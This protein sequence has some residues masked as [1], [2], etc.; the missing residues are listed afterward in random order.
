[1]SYNSMGV[2]HS[3][4]DTSV[5]SAQAISGHAADVRSAVIETLKLM[6]EPLTTPEITDLLGY[7]ECTVQPRVS[8]LK[9]DGLVVDSGVRRVGRFGRP[10]I[11]WSLA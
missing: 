2:G 10:V 8:E 5:L 1:M 3:G 11:A 7:P 4:T 9:R 6:A